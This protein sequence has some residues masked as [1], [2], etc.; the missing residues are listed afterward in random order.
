[1]EYLL[2]NEILDMI[3]ISFQENTAEKEEAVRDVYAK[4]DRLITAASAGPL[5][6][7][8]SFI[9]FIDG[10]YSEEDVA[11]KGL[12]HVLR[13]ETS[14]ELDYKLESEDLSESPIA[15]K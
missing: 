5:M 1:M 2:Q 12:L 4:F 14:K 13:V 3:L 15:L 11:I 6:T 9:D 10:L 7:A 8:I